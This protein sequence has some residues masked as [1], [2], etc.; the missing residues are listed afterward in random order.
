MIFLEKKDSHKF[1]KDQNQK[2]VILELKWAYL[3][4]PSILEVKPFIALEEVKFASIV[5]VQVIQQALFIHVQFV[6]EVVKWLEKLRLKIQ[7]SKLKWNV[8]N[9]KEV[10][11]LANKNVRFVEEK[12]L[13]W[14]QEIFIMKLKKVCEQVIKFFSKV[15]HNKDFNFILEMYI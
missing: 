9:V 3:F 13:L 7:S 15:N 4:L 6:M 14:S 5:K 10:D 8:N 1:K 2:E 12:K 11:M